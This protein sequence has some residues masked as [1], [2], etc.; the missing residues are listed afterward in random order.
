MRNLAVTNTEDAYLF[1]APAAGTACID[2]G[3]ATTKFY[4]AKECTT[5]LTTGSD[6]TEAKALLGNGKDKEC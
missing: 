1:T 2:P 6:L 4:N 3:A 5:A